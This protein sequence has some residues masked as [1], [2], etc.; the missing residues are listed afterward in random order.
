MDLRQLATLR[1]VV[2][3]GSFSAAA[4]A[5]GISQPAVS[6]QIRSLEQRVGQRLF[7]RAGP[8][9]S[10]TEAGRTVER[11]ARR[12]ADLESEL[13][14]A[15]SG[16]G[17]EVAGRLEIGS[18][19]GPGEV[20]LPRLLGAFARLHPAVIVR[21]QVHDTQTVCDLV[22]SGE[23]ELGVVGADRPQRGLIFAPFMRDELVVIALPDHPLAGR[24]EVGLGEILTFPMVLQQEG[25]G[26]RLTLEAAAKAKGLH[27]LTGPASLELGL[28]Q[29]AK[30]A[31]L[32]GLGIT[33]IS[34][35]AV[36]RELADGSIV[37]V[38][39]AGDALARDFS[40]VRRSGRTS[41]TRAEAFVAF[42]E[43]ARNVPLSTR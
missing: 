18:S 9:V 38:T 20:L 42:A 29:S 32:D 15:V 12:F 4:I 31:V 33:V 5:L 36:E 35:L 26:V 37:A 41:S 13:D 19:T 1:A 17:S 23:I 22:A 28:Q 10:L 2:E 7:D 34:R 3:H 21:L 39:I 14:A 40:L 25:S 8:R 16:L 30:A 6:G 43:A 11:Y 24:G 27:L